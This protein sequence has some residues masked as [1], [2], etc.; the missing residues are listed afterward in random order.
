MAPE[1][2]PDPPVRAST[3]SRL[4][5]VQLAGVQGDKAGLPATTPSQEVFA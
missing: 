3:G 4:I 2:L 5:P 1:C